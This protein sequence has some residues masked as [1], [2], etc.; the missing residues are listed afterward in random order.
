MNQFEVDDQVTKMN[1]LK[2]ITEI[3]LNL[4]EL[5]NSDNLKDG[6][7]SNELLTYHVTDDK[8]FTRFE[9]Q[10]PQYRKLKNGEF[11]SL[12]LRITDQNNNVITDGPQVAVVLHIRKIKS[13]IKMEYGKRLNPECSLRT[14][15]GITGTRQ[16]VIVTHNP[17]EI[18][19]AQELLVRFPNLGSDDVIIP[20][21]ANLSFNIEL[22]SAIDANKTLVSNIGR[23]IVKKLAV[24][25][26]GNEI[27]SVDDFDVLACY[28]D[29]WKTKS[30][31]RNAIRQDIISTDGCMENCIKL[32]INAGDKN[33]SNIQD[34]AIAD[35]YRNKFIIPLDFEMLDSAAPYYQ[36]GL[37]NRL[38]YEITFNDYN[39][40][41]KSAVSPKVPDAK[42]K[43]TDISLE[44]E[45]A[46]QPD[47]ARSIRSEYQHMALL[48]DR[49]LRHRKIIV[50]KSDTVWNWAFNTPC[51]PLKG[52]LVLFEEGQSYTRDTSKFY[53]PK[54]QNVS[55]LV[56]GKPNQL[57]AQGMRSFEQ[58]DEICKYFAEGKQRDND[59][60][61]IQKH[62]QLYNLS[63]V[64]YLVNKFALWLDF[65]TIDENELHGTG[66]HIENA[67]EGITLQIEKK[68][69]SAGALNAYIYLIMD[70]Q[71]NIQSGAY[72]S[73]VY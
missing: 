28:R 34:K 15:K 23:A 52:I 9:P 37:G 1:K 65:R 20:G 21:T 27:M 40:V 68:E 30:E 5:D 58:Y 24:K 13:P 61:E 57:Y 35:A 12:N 49:I 3:T 33:A 14:P 25:F 6:R 8:D 46:T 36:A 17:S 54:I 60:N 7:P 16:K 59:A 39:R 19:Q 55:V 50:N 72:V 32:R 69:E 70:A 22:T 66:R 45:I 73:A 11:T 42:Y 18:D 53:N 38:C 29:L 4:N 63:L 31:K 43:I 62:L 26:K 67:S 48:Y 51:K 71:L 41:I 47:L 56:E 44:Y 2:G 64:E 10:T